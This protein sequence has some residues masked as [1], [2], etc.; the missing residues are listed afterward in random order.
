MLDPQW[1]AAFP[2]DGGLTFY[3]CMPTKDRLPEFRRDRTDAFM[4][5]MTSSSTLL[6]CRM[7][8]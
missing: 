6:I 3:G 7:I 5:F 8:R 2:T 1:A 4:R